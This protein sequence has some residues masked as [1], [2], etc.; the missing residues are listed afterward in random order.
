[1]NI[2]FHY[3]GTFL[4]ARIAGFE[5]EEA[6]V[7]AHSAQYVDESNASMVDSELNNLLG[8]QPQPTVMDNTEY[9]KYY[10]NPFSKWSSDQL[11]EIHR[12]WMPFHFLPGNLENEIPYQGVTSYSGWFSNWKLDDEQLNHFK[13]ICNS[14]S[15]T[16]LSMIN[17]TSYSES[18]PNLHMIGLR[19][20]VLAD[21]WS[22]K[23]YIGTPAWYINDAGN[24][25]QE[26]YEGKCFDLNFNI[27][28]A[29]L[30]VIGQDKPD[31]RE[32]CASPPE[33]TYD[34]ITYL[35][36]G[37]MGHLPDYPYLHYK[38]SPQWK[39]NNQGNDKEVEKDNPTEFMSA[40]TQMVYA[41]ECIKNNN[42]FELNK[43]AS[44]DAGVKAKIQDVINIRKVD[45]SDDWNN[46][47]DELYGSKIAPFNKNAW[48][49]RFT[50]VSA[51]D[52]K[53]NTD[54]YLFNEAALNHMAL[55]EN[56]LY[57]KGLSLDK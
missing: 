34:G 52:D 10:E 51:A 54:Y 12:A 42:P 16:V 9:A 53:K 15:N 56:I 3:Y 41:L 57:D 43:Y 37:R 1:M 25:V 38:Y 35:G 17:N 28:S 31:I 30:P 19:M 27:S 36:H 29:Y 39:S 26:L 24:T 20:H 55:V 49:Q 5:E 14:N 11:T 2:D 46:L 47:I 7:I 33:A 8:M 22:H 32:Y 18:A 6:M 44:L 13:L 40:F 50:A 48:H 45:Q 21:T 4:A 23:Y